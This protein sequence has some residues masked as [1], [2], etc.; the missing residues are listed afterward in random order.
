MWTFFNYSEPLRFSFSQQGLPEIRKFEGKHYSSKRDAFTDIASQVRPAAGPSLSALR[1][2]CQ[3]R[4]LTTNTS[5]LNLA[6]LVKQWAEAYDGKRR[7]GVARV[8]K[9][10]GHSVLAWSLEEGTNGML[11]PVLRL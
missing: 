7:T 4:L 8:R 10:D 1:R 11:A 2:G 9:V 5:C 6:E 3:A